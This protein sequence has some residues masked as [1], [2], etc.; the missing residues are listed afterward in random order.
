MIVALVSMVLGSA[1][2]CTDLSAMDIKQDHRLKFVAP[3]S[4]EMVK[5]PFT[6]RWTMDDFK[7]VKPGAGAPRRSA[8][9]FAVFIDEAPVRPGR[10]LR[11]VAEGDQDCERDPQ[12]PDDG[13]L[14]GRGVYTTVKPSLK[15]DAVAPLPS[16]ETTQLHE[17]TVIL[18]DSSG[19]RIGE[20]AW[21][22]QFKLDKTALG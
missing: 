10:T 8:G 11:D 7:V 14:A 22:L 2:A 16:K 4:R 1:T 5:P 15:L 12:C 17:A 19:K 21:Y 13:Y 9:Y 3:P 18:L 6:V 20:K